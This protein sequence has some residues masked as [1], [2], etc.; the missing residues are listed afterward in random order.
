MDPMER[1]PTCR[2]T[3]GSIRHAVM[4]VAAS[5]VLGWTSVG[6]SSDPVLA[7]DELPL[8]VL[9]Q[10]ASG[11]AVAGDCRSGAGFSSHWVG[12]SPRGDLFVAS[13]SDCV[14]SSCRAWI[15]ERGARHLSLLLVLE[16][17]LTVRAGDDYPRF[18]ARAALAS[19][20]TV[21]SQYR[22]HGGSYERTNAEV[23]YQV[24]GIECGTAAQCQ[25][26]AR[27]AVE[28]ER[29][30]RAVRIYERVNGVSWI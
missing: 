22:W 2:R 29:I 6:E 7:V 11:A 24:D 27:E 15:F 8:E 9:A 1:K 14:D 17:Q 20:E 23:L 28:G 21:V 30:D 12:R 19:G 18:E 25:R 16:G 10:C 3:T 26:A 13:A 4:A 5:L